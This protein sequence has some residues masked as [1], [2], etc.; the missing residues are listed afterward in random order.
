MGSLTQTCASLGRQTASGSCFTP[1][2]N[3]CGAAIVTAPTQVTGP[4]L[5][6][7]QLLEQIPGSTNTVGSLKTYLEDMYRF[8]FWTVGIAVVLMLTVGGFM[9]MTSAGNTSRMST[10]KTVIF[11]AILGLILALMAWL[12][13]YVINPDLVNLT[14]PT[15]VTVT[16][17]AA[18]GVGTTPATP[19]A[20]TITTPFQCGQNSGNCKTGNPANPVCLPNETKIGTCD[21]GAGVNN[22]CAAA[23]VVP[24]CNSL[25][26][27]TCAPC[28]NCSVIGSNIPFKPCGL[29]QCYLN[30]ALLGKISN[31]TGVSGWRVT[32]SWPPTVAHISFCH[33]NGTCADIN[34]SGGPTDPA[35]IKTYFDAFRAAGLNVLYE[36]GA[37]CAP[38]NALGINCAS[39]PTQ[40]NLSSFHV[41]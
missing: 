29:A 9:Y 18:T 21:G 37:S 23:G 11:D 24:A 30:S 39:Y 34:N 10:A 40:T 38:Y 13:L 41:Q 5:G 8:A 17:G 16:P 22:C 7:Y 20:P 31:I 1:G 4:N 35:T 15:G 12:F 36:N 2:Q 14:L 28:A 26:G 33:A 6:N 3:C 32:E 27:V 19:A 25:P